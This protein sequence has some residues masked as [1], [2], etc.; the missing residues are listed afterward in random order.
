M[1]WQELEEKKPDK[2]THE[3]TD[4]S[5]VDFEVDF[6]IA[7]VGDKYR[8]R[9]GHLHPALQEAVDCDCQKNEPVNIPCSPWV[10]E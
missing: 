10:Q 8:C 6:V 7:A 5:V 9:Q 3:I 1:E 4:T 2:Q